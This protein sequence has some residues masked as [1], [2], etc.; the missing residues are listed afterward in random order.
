MDPNACYKR[1]WRALLE[2]D[3]D[4]AK[5]AY[6]AL[7]AWIERGGFEPSAFSDPQA[8]KQFFTF[9]LSTGRLE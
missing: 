8:R 1:W 3:A 9:S 5:E 6:L 7:R 4:E 2:E